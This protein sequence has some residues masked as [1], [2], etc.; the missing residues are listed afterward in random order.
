MP[1][2]YIVHDGAIIYPG[3]VIGKGCKIQA[4]ALIF[5]GV[6]LEDDVFVG[7]GVVF[8]NVKIPRAYKK[9]K[10]FEKTLVKR[11][12]SIGAN[13]TIICGVTIG[14]YSLIGAGSV[15]TRSVPA[16]SIVAGNPAREI[17][18]FGISLPILLPLP[19]AGIITFTPNSSAFLK[20]EKRSIASPNLNIATSQ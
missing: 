5:D 14:E 19:A 9:A 18:C 15:V 11:G 17:Y 1:E 3:A 6:T 20:K 7:P 10:E 13:A 8:T 16:N 12:A 4:G 2:E